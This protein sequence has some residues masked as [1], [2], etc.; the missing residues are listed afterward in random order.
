MNAGGTDQNIYWLL[1][2]NV[3]ALNR[4][5][6]LLSIGNIGA[7]T[8][9]IAASLFDFNMR[10]VKLRLAPAYHGDAAPHFCETES[11]TFSQSTASAGDQNVLVPEFCFIVRHPKQD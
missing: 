9:R 6:E 8:E 7:N 5:R 3:R 4:Q 1:K 10:Q 2:G 11:Q